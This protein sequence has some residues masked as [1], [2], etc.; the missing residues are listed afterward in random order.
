MNPRA[1]IAEDEPLLAQSLKNALAI[2]WPELHVIA[3][4]PNGIEALR[5]AEA[6]RP[7]VAFLD[8]RMPGM[9]GLEVAAELAD[10]LNEGEPVPRIVFVTA[11]DEYALKA[12]EL[13]A[14]DYLLKPVGAER[15]ATA[16]ERLKAQL[17]APREDLA[18]LV[19]RLQKVIAADSASTGT[20]PAEDP[21]KIIRAAVGNVVRMIPVEEVCYFQA[22]DKY[23]NVVTRDA[24]ALIRTPLKELL[25]QL[26]RHGFRQIHRGTVVNLA[27]VAAAVRDDAGRLSLRLKRRK[28]TLAVSRVYAEQ[29]RQM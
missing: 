12:F 5:L 9:S 26:P 29:F 3:L 23:T 21:L 2:A 18:Q 13:A 4:A 28:E 16:V 20:A 1:L 14:V 15:L 10:R 11:Y 22:A 25:A 19:S 27:E 6:E 17:A 8:I 7:D 24:E